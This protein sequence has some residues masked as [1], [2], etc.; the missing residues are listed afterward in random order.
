VAGFPLDGPLRLDAARVRQKLIATGQDIYGTPGVTREIYSLFTRVEPGNSGGPL[1]STAGEVGGVV[2]AKS[3]DD[4]QTGYALTV[5]EAMPVLQ[6]A[7]AAA[8]AVSTGACQL[9]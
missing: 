2:F 3:L 6:G 1:L 8:G 5:A 7:A 9:S 4:E